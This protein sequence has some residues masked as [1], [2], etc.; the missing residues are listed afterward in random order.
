MRLGIEAAALDATASG[1]P[2][3]VRAEQIGLWRADIATRLVADGV[4]AGRS[5]WKR[6]W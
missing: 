5:R 1:L 6:L 3:A 2:G 4:Q